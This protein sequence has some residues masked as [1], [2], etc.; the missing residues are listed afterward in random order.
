MAF[1]HFDD[2]MKI[3]ESVEIKNYKKSKRYLTDSLGFV[4]AQDIIA[5]HNSPEFPTS[6]MD[7]YAIKHKDLELGRQNI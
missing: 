4:L 2:S 7:G 1:L 5:D 6:A 3:I